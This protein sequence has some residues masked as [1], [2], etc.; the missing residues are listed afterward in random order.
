MDHKYGFI[1]HLMN[2]DGNG[3]APNSLGCLNNRGR[4]QEG[5]KYERGEKMGQ[6]QKKG[7]KGAKSAFSF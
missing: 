5:K 4:R 2:T 7:K 6:S 3:G 1:E